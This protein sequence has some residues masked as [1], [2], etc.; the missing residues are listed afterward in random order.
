MDGWMEDVYIYIYTSI[1][2]RHRVRTVSLDIFACKSVG[3]GR[4]R[5]LLVNKDSR[6]IVQGSAGTGRG[7]M[8]IH[9]MGSV[10]IRASIYA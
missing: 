10:Y 7:M 8:H 3:K 5:E 6:Q 9:N 2:Q 1:Y 4:V